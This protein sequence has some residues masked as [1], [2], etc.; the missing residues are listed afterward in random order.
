MKTRIGVFICDCGGSIK[1]INFSEVRDKAAKLPDVA[2]VNLASQLCLR[3][4]QEAMSSSVKEGDI[5]RVVVAAC[6]PDLKEHV[7]T[8]A[9]ES[10]GRNGHLLSVANIREQCAWAHP[11]DVSQKALQL[12]KMAVNRARLLQ[13]REKT[14][15]PVKKEVLVVG[16]GFS[17]MSSAIQL[18]E[19][20]LPTTLLEKEPTLRGGNRNLEDLYGPD[21]SSM[22]KAVEGNKDIEVLTSSEVVG[23][24]GRVGSFRVRIRE[25]QQE[26]S[27]VFGAVVLAT[28]HEIGFGASDLRPSAGANITSLQGLAQMF[29]APSLER[30]PETLCF[31]SD[32][33]EENS[34]FSSLAILNSALTARRKW[35]S[36]VYVLCRNVKVDSD[37][38]EKLYCQ[39]REAG[40]VFL[41][42]EGKPRIMAENGRVKMEARDILVGENIVL[43][44]D[45]LVAE[46]KFLP[47]TGTA[48]L[49]SILNIDTD[50]LGFYQKE[51]VHLYPVASGRRGIFFVG[52][53]RGDL[54]LDR[55]LSDVSS[56]VTNVYNVLWSGRITVEAERVKVDAQKCRTCL[57]CLR[58]CPHSAI[59]LVRSNSGREMAE[60]SDLAC[61]GCGI[62]TA[63]CPA[64]AIEYEGYSDQQILSQIEAIGAL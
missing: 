47:A 58:V 41:K 44:P 21:I 22:V 31:V 23:I 38:A 63:I 13:P 25:G 1:N 50:S 26:D 5:D 15:L 54:G 34:R 33:S 49:S 17:G 64:K 46:A 27:R 18:S 32:L 37:G 56:V 7:F 61:D 62:C 52:S 8:Q 43:A 36:Q 28:G 11:E 39:V 9:M 4:G 24:E 35:D 3:A 57:T 29:Q 2:L 40:V 45:L 55:V 59:E 53:C 51:N 6:S 12:I 16:G 60:I 19:L 30:K 14:E 20:G 48:P 42:F 10:V